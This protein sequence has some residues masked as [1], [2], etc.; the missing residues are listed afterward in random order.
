MNDKEKKA[1]ERMKDI[2]NYINENSKYENYEGYYIRCRSEEAKMFETVLN[3]IE[4]QNHI[5]E[6]KEA[7]I[8]TMTHNEEVLVA[9]IEKKDKQIDLMAEK[10]KQLREA[11]LEDCFIPR[12]YRDIDDCLKTTCEE[13]IKQYFE[14]KA[15]EDKQ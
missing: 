7:L 1:I 13:C 9:E 8:D 4:N 10:L 14:K 12:S 2:T 5:I 6:G 15:E 11:S 3:L